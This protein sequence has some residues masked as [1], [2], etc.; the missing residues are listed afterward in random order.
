[1]EERDNS[2]D[3]LIGGE[4]QLRRLSREEAAGYLEQARRKELWNL[5]ATGVYEA[6]NYSLGE[7]VKIA[8]INS[9]ADVGH[10][11]IR[12]RFGDPRGINYVF[13]ERDKERALVMD[14]DKLRI[15]DVYDLRDLKDENGHGTLIASIITGKNIGIAPKAKVYALK[16]AD[17]AGYIRD[18]QM[19]EAI[20]RCL[21]LDVDLINLSLSRDEPDSDLEVAC[22]QAYDKGIILVAS[23]G[24]KGSGASFPATYDSAISVASIAQNKRRDKFSCIW[25]TNDIAAPGRNIFGACNLKQ[26]QNYES[27]YATAGGTSM[28]AAHVTGILALALSRLKS[29]GKSIDPKEL[30]ELMRETADM[31]KISEEEIRDIVVAFGFNLIKPNISAEEFLKYTYGAGIVRADKLLERLI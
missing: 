9:G 22:K 23:A 20:K 28:A 5:K 1:M 29:E 4:L 27:S 18:E 7:G 16:V 13:W 12:D 2:I 30:E 11:E 15:S 19:V 17:K 26:D 10:P 31:P 25:P 3:E 8:V 24:N 14:K 21:R 6:Q